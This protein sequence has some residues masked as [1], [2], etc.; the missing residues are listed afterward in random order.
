M[1]LR[2]I[3][4]VKALPCARC[5]LDPCDVVTVDSVDVD[6]A[7][8][9]LDSTLGLGLV[10]QQD[11]GVGFQDDAV[12]T[13]AIEDTLEHHVGLSVDLGEIYV[14]EVAFLDQSV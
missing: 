1:E 2:P 5:R 12:G 3:E 13:D 10:V 11:S 6:A 4:I 8:V 14:L 9:D 7:G